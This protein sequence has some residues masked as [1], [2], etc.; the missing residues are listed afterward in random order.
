V[1]NYFTKPDALDN[2]VFVM[3]VQKIQ[4]WLYTDN[5]ASFYSI[6]L[7]QAAILLNIFLE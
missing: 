4:L 1:E 5:K 6:I 3:I 2:L 7:K